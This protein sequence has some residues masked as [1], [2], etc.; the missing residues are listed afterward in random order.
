M[1]DGGAYLIRLLGAAAEKDASEGA[2]IPRT[3]Y[4]KPANTLLLL[5]YGALVLVLLPAE[6]REIDGTQV[7]ISWP[8]PRNRASA[9]C[10][11]HTPRLAL[12]RPRLAQPSPVLRT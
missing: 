3:V 10:V 2:A 6:N 8:H 9:A 4:H 1:N 5:P 12:P 7:C 11:V